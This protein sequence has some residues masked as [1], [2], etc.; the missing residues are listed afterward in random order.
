MD[1]LIFVCGAISGAIMTFIVLV[2]YGSSVVRTV[3][4]NLEWPHEISRSKKEVKAEKT[5]QAAH[6]P[7]V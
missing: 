5:R 6:A 3:L 4:K 1:V 2:F 7:R